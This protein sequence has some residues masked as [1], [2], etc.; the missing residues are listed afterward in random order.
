MSITWKA[1]CAAV[2]LPP[3]GEILAGSEAKT[4]ESKARGREEKQLSDDRGGVAA[5]ADVAVVGV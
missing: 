3:L 4:E 5:T 1:L 2:T